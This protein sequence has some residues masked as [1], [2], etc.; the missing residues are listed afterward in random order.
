MEFARPEPFPGRSMQPRT[1]DGKYELVRELGKGGMGAVYEARH[2]LTRRK[3][4]LKLILAEELAGKKPL[5]AQRRFEREARA[6]GSIESRHVVS[7]LDTGI[8]VSTNDHYIVMELL[9][10]ED[11]GQLIRR[12]GKLPTEIVLS[13][14]W[15]VCLGLRRAHEQGI[16]HRDIKSGNIF[17]ARKDD[18]HVEVKIL[19]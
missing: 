2:L 19:D 14:A 15:Q 3:V 4:A 7:V 6:A 8:D 18:G 5:V 11:L 10:G 13:I 17:L 9:S 12:V 16:I 1:I